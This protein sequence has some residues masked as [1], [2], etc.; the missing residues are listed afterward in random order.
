MDDEWNRR[1]ERQVE[2]EVLLVSRRRST[3]EK[4][5]LL[6]RPL[7][8]REL[9][10]KRMQTSAKLAAGSTYARR[11]LD[12]S[13]TYPR[14]PPIELSEVE[15]LLL[16]RPSDSPDNMKF[17]LNFAFPLRKIRLRY[18]SFCLSQL[19]QF[20]CLSRLSIRT[21]FWRLEE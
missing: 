19:R 10:P 16:C 5:S 15:W 6:S 9:K 11:M 8:P 7:S 21:L 2:L 1:L 17:K 3:V 20:L 4:V 13:S 12:V 18:R 14:E